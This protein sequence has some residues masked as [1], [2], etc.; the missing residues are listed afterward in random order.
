MALYLTACSVCSCVQVMDLT[1][2]LEQETRKRSLSQS[3]LKAQKQQ[4]SALA[5]SE[6]Q[7]KQELNQLLDMKQNLEK[8]NQKLHRSGSKAF[9]NEPNLQPHSVLQLWCL[10]CFFGCSGS[11]V[12]LCLRLWLTD[13][14]YRFRE[15]QE[16]DGQLKELKDQLEAEQYF[17][18]TLLF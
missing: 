14:W 7:L 15:K 9:Q 16:A 18:V 3:D 6:K 11:R 5:S 2:R 1:L 17:T 12:Q 13:F 10:S 8:Q 4:V